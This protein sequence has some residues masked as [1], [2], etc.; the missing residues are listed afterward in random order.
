M[1][2]S[3]AEPDG[4]KF[5]WVD[6]LWLLFLGGFAVLPPIREKHKQLILLGFGLFQIFE[7]RILRAVPPSLRGACSVLIKIVLATLLVWH[8][9]LINSSYY[10]IYFVPAVSAAMLFDAWAT[11]FWTALASAAY[12]SFLIPALK[13]FEL[14]PGGASELTIRI[15]SLFLVAIVVNRFVT[16]N[17]RQSLRYQGLAETLAQTNR[18]LEL[19]QADARR[20]E[21]LA[22]LG[23]LTA[24]LAHEIRN[25]LGI[26]K[27]SAETL[28]EKLR[29]AEPLAT[30]LASYISSEVDKLNGLVSRFLD[31]ARPLRLNLRGE[32]VPPLIDRAL[33]AVHDRWPAAK[34]Q[35]ER[36]Y[37]ADCPKALVDAELCEQIFTNLALNAYEVMSAQGG[38]LKVRVTA[39]Y[40]SHDGK[41]VRG[42]LV[43][44]QDTGPGIAPELWEQIF[45]PFFTTK[46]EGVGLGLSIV[47]KI[48]DDHGGWIRVIGEPGQGACFRL[49]LPAADEKPETGN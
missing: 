10:L 46:K 37:A 47:S 21:R 45:N 26:I 12:C 14:T 48:V 38:K 9:G 11:L 23:Q 31:F 25:P 19:A 16:E 1:A 32:D 15:L 40:D 43:D 6:M 29:P 13:E 36:D 39:G 42:I 27:G 28:T 7:P 33:K 49:F 34:V 35:V 41:D 5:A 17:R 8:T 24:G 20:S 2:S 44:V 18:R 3:A 4:A 22:A 30:E